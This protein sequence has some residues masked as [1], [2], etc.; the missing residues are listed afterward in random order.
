MPK[1]NLFAIGGVQTTGLGGAGGYNFSGYTNSFNVGNGLSF[2]AGKAIGAAG[3]TSGSGSG[4]FGGG[5]AA[6]LQT[7]AGVGLEV[8]G[9]IGRSEDNK[10][11]LWDVADP[12]HHLAGGRESAVGN[13]LGDTGVGLFKAGAQSGNPWLMLAGGVSK[14]LGSS[15]NGLFGTKV[16]KVAL[17]RANMSINTNRNFVSNA[18]TL[19]ELRGPASMTQADVYT[20]SLFN[21]ADDKNEALRKDMRSAFNWADASMRNNARNIISDKYED[22]MRRFSAFG[23]PLDIAVDNN[24]MGAINYGFMQDYLTN[25]KQ[26]IS[27]RNKMAGLT[28]MPAFMPNSFAIGGDLQV[29]GG[30]WTTGLTHIDAGL[31]HEENPNEGVQ[32]GVDSE[33][34]PNLVEENETV[35]NDYVFSNR[36]L[37]DEATKQMFRLPKKKDITFADISK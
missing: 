12:M 32:L 18:K 15:I 34:I 1:G 37:A 26:E 24:D 30:D 7:A 31:S 17:D 29:N 21:S 2:D 8:A 3:G 11:G 28:Q 14:F 6:A 10:R 22:N 36:I 25:K 4:G 13:A 9:N 5:K 33:G 23:G 35:W 16:D 27:N 19:D 20:G